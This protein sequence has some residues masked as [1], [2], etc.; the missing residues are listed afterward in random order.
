MSKLTLL[1]IG[2]VKYLL[3]CRLGKMVSSVVIGLKRFIAE[4]VRQFSLASMMTSTSYR[5]GQ[6]F[7]SINSILRTD[8]F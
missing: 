4:L 8:C 7:F 2:R 5:T 3:D 1:N 6:S